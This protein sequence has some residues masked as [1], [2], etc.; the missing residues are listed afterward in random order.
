MY[1]S[2]NFSEVVNLDP[3][4]GRYEGSY[5]DFIDTFEP[6]IVLLQVEIEGEIIGEFPEGD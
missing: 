5:I 4:K 6:D 2:L 3:Q 1:L